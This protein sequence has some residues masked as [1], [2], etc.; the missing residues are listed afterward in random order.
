MGSL[1]VEVRSFVISSLSSLPEFQDVETTFGYRVGS[2]RR[3][4]CWTQQARFNHEPAGMRA[5]KTHRAEDAAFD[6]VILVE[7]IGK[8]AEWSCTRALE[9]GV[10]AEDW[11]ATH[12]NWTGQVEGLNWLQIQGDGA[13][14]DGFSDKASLAELTY[15]IRYQARLT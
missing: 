11:C 12:A 13:L 6:L 10:A 7:G 3:E 8:T 14:V 5:T 1:L 15:P 2:K 4:R 9:I